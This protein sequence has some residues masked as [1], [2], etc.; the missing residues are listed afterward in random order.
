MA[1]T[2]RSWWPPPRLLAALRWGVAAV[3]VGFGGYAKVLGGVPR[4]E[5]IVSRFVGEEWSTAVTLA[6]GGGEMLLGLWVLSKRFPRA[7]ATTQTAGIVAM[8]SLELWKARDLLLAP[9]PMVAANAV[10]LSVAWTVAIGAWR[11]GDGRRC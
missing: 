7:C 9:W 4:H 11:E 5:Q 6:V 8:N 2:V 1:D 10:L 3:W